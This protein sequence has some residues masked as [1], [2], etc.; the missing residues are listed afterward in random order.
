MGT[1]HSKFH[2]RPEY[3]YFGDTIPFYWKGQYHVFY[4]EGQFDPY[5]RV[6]FTPFN[7]LV[8]TD[9]VNWEELPVA[10]NLGGPEDVDMSLGTGT[11]IAKG[12]QFYLLYC[13]RRFNPTSETVCLA[14][15]PDLIHWE[16]HPANPILVPDG[17]TYT[18]SDFRDPFPFWNPS[19]NCFSMLVASKLAAPTTPRPGCLAVA[20][21]HDL[22]HWGLKPPFYAPNAHSMALECPDIFEALGRWHLIY[23]AESRTFYRTAEDLSGPWESMTPDPPDHYFRGI[24]APK[25]LTDGQRR[26]LFGWIGTRAGEQDFGDHQWGGDM[27]VPRE[28]VPLPG[29]QL[30]EVCPQEILDACGPAIEYGLDFRLGYW[31]AIGGNLFARRQDGLAYAVL[32]DCPPSVLVEVSVKF[33]PGTQAAGICFRARADLSSCYALRLE[34]GFHQS[35]VERWDLNNGPQK[36]M[37]LAER[38]LEVVYSKPVLVKLMIDSDIIEV[39]IDDLVAMCCHGYDFKTG[40][41]GFFVENGE[42]IFE[43]VHLRQLPEA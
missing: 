12:D 40:E 37:V 5:R 36:V 1:N 9:L 14:T 32:S 11:V 26:F 28:L 13:G 15:S 6:R 20:E 35:T 34:P 4:L 18:T 19:R 17:T 21:S 8:S 3:G 39:F 41:L 30:A 16:K 43:E 7:H 24:Y 38:H 27:L 23:S 42:A 10:V 33:S 29:G 25:T 31:Q 22:I 2:Y